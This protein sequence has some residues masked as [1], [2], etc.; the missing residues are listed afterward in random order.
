MGQG[1]VDAF[2]PLVSMKTEGRLM[3]CPEGKKIPQ[4]SVK[5]ILLLKNTYVLT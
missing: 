5:Q 3:G 2:N 1:K 4:A